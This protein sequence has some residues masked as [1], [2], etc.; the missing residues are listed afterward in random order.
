MRITLNDNLLRRGSPEEIQAGM[1]HEMGHYVLNHVY[2]FLVYLL[3]IIAVW[4][5]ALQWSLRWALA[6]WGEKWQIRGIGDTA[7]LPLVLLITSLFFFLLTPVMNTM[8]R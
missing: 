2:K 5:A 7:V 1:G 6:R 4:F 8:I 3:V